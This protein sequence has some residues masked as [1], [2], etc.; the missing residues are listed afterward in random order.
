M[1]AERK[2]AE[3]GCGDQIRLFAA[4]ILHGDLKHRAWLIDAAEAFVAGNAVPAPPIDAVW[5]HKKRGSSYTIKGHARVQCETPLQDGEL[6]LLYQ[7]VVSGEYSVRRDDEFFD[8]RFEQIAPP[9]GPMSSGTA[10]NT[11]RIK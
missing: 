5:R 10:P 1:M 11:D 7:D 3:P 2:D 6:P 4:A 9:T 8:G